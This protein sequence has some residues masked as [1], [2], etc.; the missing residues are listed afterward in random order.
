MINF[1]IFKGFVTKNTDVYK[2]LDCVVFPST[3]QLEGFGLVLIEAMAH[4]VPVIASS[5]GPV[6]EVVGDAA[7]LYSPGNKEE[8][9]NALVAVLQ[10]HALR[11]ELIEKG[12]ARVQ[13]KYSI[14]ASSSKMIESMRTAL[15]D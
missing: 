5:V 3:W 9:R 8:L 1:V 2:N 12:Y 6:P 13:D 15:C 4:R 11:N 14:K 7:A 10:S